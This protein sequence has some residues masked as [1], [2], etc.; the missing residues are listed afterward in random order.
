MVPELSL[1]HLDAQEEAMKEELEEMTQ[2][3]EAL[4]TRVRADELRV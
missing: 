1:P 3:S 4:L 2:I